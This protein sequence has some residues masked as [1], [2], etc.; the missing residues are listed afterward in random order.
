[1]AAH[2][3]NHSSGSSRM[4]LVLSENSGYPALVYR[5]PQLSEIKND[6]FIKIFCG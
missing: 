3:I 1:M 5:E 4:I 6:N 2:I